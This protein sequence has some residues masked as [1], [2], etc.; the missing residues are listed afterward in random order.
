MMKVRY[1]VNQYTERFDMIVEQ[2][3]KIDV[4]LERWYFT[5]II[6]VVFL[7]FLSLRVLKYEIT[8]WTS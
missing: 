6:P 5:S 2:F 3:P 4:S 7:S 1:I 8:F